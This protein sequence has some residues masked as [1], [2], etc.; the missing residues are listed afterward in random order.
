MDN[1]KPVLSK[2]EY[3]GNPWRVVLLQPT[4]KESWYIYNEE[5]GVYKL[6][7]PVGQLYQET[8]FYQIARELAYRLNNQKEN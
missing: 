7:G 6:I 3:V 8:N 5:T 2:D 4:S 1:E